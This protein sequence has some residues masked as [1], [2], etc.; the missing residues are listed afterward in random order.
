MTHQQGGKD[1]TVR[2]RDLEHSPGF[3]Q[4]T[5]NISNVH[6]HHLTLGPG[7]SRLDVLG[8]DNKG[9]GVKLGS[10]GGLHGPSVGGGLGR[11][12]HEAVS[13]HSLAAEGDLQ[14]YCLV[15]PSSS[16][17]ILDLVR[18]RSQLRAHQGDLRLSRPLQHRPEHQRQRALAVGSN[19]EGLRVKFDVSIRRGAL[20]RR[21]DVQGVG[22]DDVLCLLLAAG[23]IQLDGCQALG[24]D[25]LEGLLL[26]Q[27]VP[28]AVVGEGDADGGR[29]LLVGVH[30]DTVAALQI[31][32][33]I[34]GV[35]PVHLDG[36][37]SIAVRRRVCELHLDCETLP[38]MHPI[39]DR[40]LRD[41]RA[42]AVHFLERQRVDTRRGRCPLQ[43]DDEG[44]PVRRRD[45]HR[46]LVLLR[47]V[48]LPLRRLALR[49]R[50]L[51]PG[52]TRGGQRAVDDLQVGVTPGGDNDLLLAEEE[53]P[54]LGD[55][56]SDHRAQAPLVGRWVLADRGRRE[57]EIL[58]LFLPH[59]R[60]KS[61]RGLILLRLLD[62]P[63]SHH[64][65]NRLVVIQHTPDIINRQIPLA[66]AARVQGYRQQDVVMRRYK[67][68]CRGNGDNIAVL[69]GDFEAVLGPE[70]AKIVEMELFR[71][72]GPEDHCAE[73]EGLLGELDLCGVAD[74]GNVYQMHLLTQVAHRLQPQLERSDPV[75]RGE[76]NIHRDGLLGPQG[77]RRKWV[78][79]NSLLAQ[80]V[81]LWVL[82]GKIHSPL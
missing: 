7:A 72:G 46:P 59:L 44:L 77:H 71:G 12:M 82:Q 60:R 30:V 9:I 81:S 62:T 68:A 8:V 19:L 23:S 4:G 79:G 78:P 6:R 70:V 24:G 67:P 51:V 37:G 1:A 43:L 5:W 58:H 55:L 29:A 73:Q 50:L 25:E 39:L 34:E 2:G 76:E 11:A 80:G 20:E 41:I 32:G 28:G 63:P 15:Q 42:L 56:G 64:Q 61:Q 35:H 47:L 22:D 36:L 52:L 18:V 33:Q 17:N 3:S 14:H 57:L 13:F 21:L 45:E 54:V 53:L 31:R 75:L 38:D 40:N 65:L 27:G 48:L 16:R 10:R 26:D 49:R 69:G 66:H 74:P